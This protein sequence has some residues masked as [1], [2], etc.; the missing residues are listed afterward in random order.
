MRYG[1]NSLFSQ[2]L[3]EDINIIQKYDLKLKS[4]K[5]KSDNPFYLQDFLNYEHPDFNNR[6]GLTRPND[7]EIKHAL[8]LNK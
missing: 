7:N 1:I 8:N 2:I 6:Y 5:K 3:K 4:P